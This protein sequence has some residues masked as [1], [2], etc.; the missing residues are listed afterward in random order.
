MFFN[1]KKENILSKFF[2]IAASY[3]Q[4]NGTEICFSEGEAYLHLY[5]KE[6]TGFI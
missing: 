3:G 4:P 5:K 1:S 6:F 2:M